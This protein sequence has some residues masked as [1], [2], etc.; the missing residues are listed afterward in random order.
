MPYRHKAASGSVIW[1][2]WNAICHQLKEVCEPIIR[3]RVKDTISTQLSA[4]P[5]FTETNLTTQAPIFG[6]DLVSWA[7][8]IGFFSDQTVDSE[9]SGRH[10]RNNP[11]ASCILHDLEWHAFCHC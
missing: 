3:L 1:K 7:E 11:L 2:R 5:S 6:F 4:Y 10:L 9:R 8:R